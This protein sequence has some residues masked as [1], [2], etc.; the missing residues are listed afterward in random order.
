MQIKY[1]LSS[2]FHRSRSPRRRGD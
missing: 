1:W 2:W